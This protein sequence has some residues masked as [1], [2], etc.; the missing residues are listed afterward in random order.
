MTW[1][2]RITIGRILLIPVL[3]G[4]LLYYEHSRQETGMADDRLRVLAL[5]V[6]VV[7]ALS[8]AV[9]GYLARHCNQRSKLGSV[10][11]P[12]ADKLL[13]LASLITLSFVQI[14]AEPCFPLWFPLIIISRDGILLV[15]ILL[16]NFVIKH[17][18]VRPHWIGKVATFFQ[19]LAIGAALLDWNQRYWIC[20]AGGT[21][22]FA[23][24]F[25]YLWDGVGQAHRSG[26]GEAQ[27]DLATRKKR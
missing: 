22:T 2:N 9:D 13:M 6:F 21:L 14:G 17:V 3:V 5:V 15:G 12:V 4:L 26:Y 24:T 8:D 25:V 20:V 16:L 23:S 18:E 19:L 7:A 11:D 10:L 1:A 27:P